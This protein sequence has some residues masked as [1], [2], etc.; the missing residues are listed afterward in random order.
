MGLL[1]VNIS[2]SDFHFVHELFM[3]FK[4]KKQKC[5]RQAKFESYLPWGQTGI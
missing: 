1:H 5:P 4:G 3:S 2:V